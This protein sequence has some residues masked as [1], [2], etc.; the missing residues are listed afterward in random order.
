V[1]VIGLA[2][3]VPLGLALG[4]FAWREFATNFGVVPVPVLP[5]LPLAVLA[6]AVL[7]VANALALGPAVLAARSR[8]GPLLRTE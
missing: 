2:V 7:A 5:P 1:A 6:G 8:P 3:G 4:Q